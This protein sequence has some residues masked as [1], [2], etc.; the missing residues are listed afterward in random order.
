M[1]T[2][3][4]KRCFLKS[5]EET[6]PNIEVSANDFVFVGRSPECALRDELISR[7]QLKLKADF[8]RN[9]LIFEVIGANPSVLNNAELERNKEY[10]AKHGDI[11]EMV[12]SKYPY[13]VCF[14]NLDGNLIDENANENTNESVQDSGVNVNVSTSRNVS[15]KNGV[16]ANLNLS[17]ENEV[18][19]EEPIAAINSGNAIK[20]SKR[21]IVD[22]D[23]DDDEDNAPLK[24]RK[25]RINLIRDKDPFADTAAWKSYNKGKLIVH[26]TADCVASNKIAAYDMDGTLITT[27]SGRVFP[28]SVDDWKIAF[29]TVKSTLTKIHAEKCKIVIF[30]N[31]AGLAAGRTV[32]PDLRTKIEKIIEKIAV[33]VQVFIA[34][35][36]SQFRKPL[37]MMWQALSDHLNDDVSIDKSQ[38]FYVGDAAGRPENKPLKKKKDHSSVDRLFALNLHL[39]FFTPEEHFLKQS[40][41]KWKKPEFEPRDAL[42]NVPDS[43]LHPPS[44]Q[45]TSNSVEVIILVGVPGSGKSSFCKNH[46]VSAGY[47]VINQ[48]TLK[49]RQKCV[50]RCD[51]CLKDKKKV[52]IDN[53]NGKPEDRAHYIKLAKTHK[54]KCRCFVMATTFTHAEHNI[55]F[56]ELL[57]PSHAKISRMVLNNFKKYY[58]KPAL[59][60]GIHEIVTVNFIPTFRNMDEKALYGMYLLGS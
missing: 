27:A 44:S 6:Y 29:G 57:D 53:T 24:R 40:K 9:R 38:S 36:D 5:V 35:D 7:K 48:D 16:N 60:E 4:Q 13:K 51:E 55:K 19:A 39:P 58:K 45:L 42:N 47:E 41:S 43:L 8:N 26:T 33:P 46:L 52:V 3:A 30:T 2:G 32:L 23:D 1:S 49:S 50:K 20:A 10:L 37:T 12:P 18:I 34:T 22:S 17:C 14:E 31:Q 56:R 25:S 15:H 28:T 11:I 54:V 59:S 21:R